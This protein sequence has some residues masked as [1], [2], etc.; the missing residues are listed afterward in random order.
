MKSS[1]ELFAQL[2]AELADQNSQWR[3]ARAALESVDP[4][5]LLAVDFRALEDFAAA[6]ASGGVAAPQAPVCGIRV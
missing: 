6:C 5:A 2:Q 3:A 4:R 1:N